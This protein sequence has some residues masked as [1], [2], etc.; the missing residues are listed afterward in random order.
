M[1]EYGGEEDG[2]EIREDESVL[3]HREEDTESVDE[4]EK[5][6]MDIDELTHTEFEKFVGD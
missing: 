6:L 4:G 1:R 5:E 2:E 3:N